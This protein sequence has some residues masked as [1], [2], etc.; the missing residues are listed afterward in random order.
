MRL[1]L[2]NY[3]SIHAGPTGPGGRSLN[4]A[5]TLMAAAQE[6]VELDVD[7]QCLFATSFNAFIP[8]HKK[9]Q[10]STALATRIAPEN[11]LMSFTQDDAD[12]LMAQ[13]K[14]LHVDLG[15]VKNIINDMRLLYKRCAYTGKAIP[16]AECEEYEHK[17][18]LESLNRAVFSK[19]RVW[20]LESINGEKLELTDE[21]FIKL[22]CA[23]SIEEAVM[24]LSYE[25]GAVG[26]AA[27][28]RFNDQP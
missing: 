17:S 23:T 10:L 3:T 20:R 2:R 6:K 16:L 1:Q 25:F 11:R 8:E 28:Y 27:N 24:S 18:H 21:A 15:L 22:A 13:S 26:F 12:T 14:L 19:F 9:P 7:L 4:Y 5:L